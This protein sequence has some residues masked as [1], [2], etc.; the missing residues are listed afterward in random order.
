MSE[1][2]N[3][4]SRAKLYRS[5]SF[6]RE[7]ADSLGVGGMIGHIASCLDALLETRRLPS[8]GENNSSAAALDAALIMIAVGTIQTNK[9]AM[10]SLTDSLSTMKL[11]KIVD[12][13]GPAKHGILV[14][15][16]SDLVTDLK[17]GVRSILVGPRGSLPRR[18][19]S[20]R[21]HHPGRRFVCWRRS[22][23]SSHL[24]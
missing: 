17:G 18:T 12:I 5:K 23:P 19:L 9:M 15:A 24:G 16:G 22:N 8:R 13:K 21:L 14:A 6:R 3:Q 1:S 10:L 4:R 20:Y 2:D 11:S 7:L